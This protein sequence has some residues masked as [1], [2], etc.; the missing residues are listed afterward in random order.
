[1]HFVAV[2]ILTHFHAYPGVAALPFFSTLP[3]ITSCCDH[4][5]VLN[6]LS[7]VSSSTPTCLDGEMRT[8]MCLYRAA[9]VS[10]PTIPRTIIHPGGSGNISLKGCI[11]TLAV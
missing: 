5:V 7:S 2:Y 4:Y 9:G 6:S 8:T 3:K 1:M 11:S 10:E